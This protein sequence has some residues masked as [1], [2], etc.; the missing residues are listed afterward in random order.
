MSSNWTS[1]PSTKWA[2][3]SSPRRTSRSS[4]IWT[5]GSSSARTH[6]IKIPHTRTKST[7]VSSNG[8]PPVEFPVSGTEP[9]PRA[10]GSPPSWT[11]RWSPGMPR[12]AEWRPSARTQH[13]TW[14]GSRLVPG[15]RCSVPMSRWRRR[16]SART[17]G[18]VTTA[19]CHRRPARTDCPHRT[20]CLHWRTWSSLQPHANR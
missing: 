6:T 14:T 7:R 13:Q 15:A 5:S 16:S 12:S 1:R 18:P 10:S 8:A 19:S 2:S 3:R 20:W 17:R 9:S 11:V 4:P